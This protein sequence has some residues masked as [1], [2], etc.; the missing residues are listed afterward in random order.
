M[1]KVFVYMPCYIGNNNH[2]KKELT[3]TIKSLGEYPNIFKKI[4]LFICQKDKRKIIQELV[5]KLSLRI[6]YEIIYIQERNPRFLPICVFQYIQQDQEIEKDD[7]V[8]YDEA[9]HILH[10]DE[11]F[12]KDICYELKL[13]NIIMPHRFWKIK[14]ISNREYPTYWKY[15]VGNIF[16]EWISKY[17]EIFNRMDCWTKDNKTHNAYAGCFFSQKKTLIWIPLK[18]YY[19]LS[20][21]LVQLLSFFHRYSFFRN[22]IQILNFYIGYPFGLVLEAPSLILSFIWKKVLKPVNFDVLYVIHL[23]QNSYV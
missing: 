9:D 18:K 17:N 8:F 19:W 16:P 5:D 1:K 12:W 6:D 7:I 4:K 2:F 22:I 11:K 21:F 14:A 13:W 23:S 15:L 10:I 3:A 20:F